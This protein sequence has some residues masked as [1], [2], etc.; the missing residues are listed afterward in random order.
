MS[1]SEPEKGREPSTP[2][3]GSRLTKPL[4]Q[5]SRVARLLSRENHL[6]SEGDPGRAA[7]PMFAAPSLTDR[8]R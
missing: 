8:L 5:L 2:G 4:A 1:M 3:E 7:S 6:S